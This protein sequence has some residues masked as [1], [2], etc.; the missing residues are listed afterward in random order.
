MNLTKIPGSDRVARYVPYG[1]LR[2]DA[3]G[4]VLGILLTAFQLRSDETDGLS[5]TWLEF[6]GTNYTVCMTE[7]D[8]RMRARMNVA[9]K[10]EYAIAV[11]QAIYDAARERGHKVRVI[12]DPEE[13]NEAHVSILRYPA[14]DEMF[15][16]ALADSVFISREPC[17]QYDGR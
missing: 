7:V 3:D 10:A 15:L 4:N 14:A 9:R 8:R 5:V 16:Q 12:H 1:R 17:V 2:T 13:G 6:F 11:V